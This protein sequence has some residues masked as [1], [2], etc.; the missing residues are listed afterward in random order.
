[1]KKNK[2][3]SCERCQQAPIEHNKKILMNTNRKLKG[4]QQTTIEHDEQQQ[5]IEKELR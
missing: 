1:V 2:I 3:A 5:N 4:C